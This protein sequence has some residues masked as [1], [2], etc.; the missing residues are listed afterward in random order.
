MINHRNLYLLFALY[1]PF[2]SIPAQADE[3]AV[4]KVYHPYVH[5]EREIEWR[6]TSAD[7]EQKHQLALGKSFSDQL[8]LELY[9]IGEKGNG[10]DFEVSNYE[11]EAKWQLTEQGE[12]DIDWGVITEFEGSRHEDS[13]EFSTALLMEKEFNR[14]IG[15]L[16]LWGIY[17]W[18]DDVETEL[19]S[20][21]TAQIRYRYSR[22]FEPALEFY[23]GPDTRALG[24]VIMGDLRLGTRRKLHWETGV[25]FGLDSKTPNNTFRLL[26]EFEF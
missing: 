8:F 6:M 22:L 9:L 15:T 18:G 4:D 25:I 2:I 19:E 12:Y 23:S 7:G 26:T 17:E 5:L 24:P 10:E 11:F 13:W 21:L 14:W 20:S 1:L 16:N 3:L